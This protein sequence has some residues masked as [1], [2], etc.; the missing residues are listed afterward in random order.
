MVFH[1]PKLV[2]NERNNEAHF[3]PVVTC[4]S[5]WRFLSDLGA[6]TRIQSS[7]NLVSARQTFSEGD[8]T[9]KTSETVETEELKKFKYICKSKIKSE[10]YVYHHYEN[11]IQVSIKLSLKYLTNP[12]ASE[13]LIYFLRNFFI[14]K[15][16]N[17]FFLHDLLLS[18]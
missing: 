3:N 14:S 12:K 13:V 11:S 16:E 4:L 6:F 5:K 9:F 17:I 15:F 1:A 18:S 2:S 7:I 10:K 8:V